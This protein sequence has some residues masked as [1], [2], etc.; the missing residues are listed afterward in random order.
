MF[1]VSISFSS[2]T[3]LATSSISEESLV[4]YRVMGKLAPVC[5]RE[6]GAGP[7][8]RAR[9]LLARASDVMWNERCSA[10]SREPY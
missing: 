9:R 3:D 2:V 8:P 5:S 10:A 6:Q 7:M 4:E 1:G